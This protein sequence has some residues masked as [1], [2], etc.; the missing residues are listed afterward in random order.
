MSV[1]H[2]WGPPLFAIT[3]AHRPWLGRTRCSPEWWIGRTERCSEQQQ[4]LVQRL[5]KKSEIKEF[6]RSV[7]F[8]KSRCAMVV[9]C[10]SPSPALCWA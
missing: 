5:S 7:F 10:D 4:R 6:N 9:G 2:D 3:H 1:H 8:R